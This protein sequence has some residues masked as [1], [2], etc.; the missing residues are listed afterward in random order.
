MSDRVI[1]DGQKIK[2][3]T[4]DLRTVVDCSRP[5]VVAR[6]IRIL[7]T[8]ILA[9]RDIAGGEQLKRDL[10]DERSQVLRKEEL[11]RVEQK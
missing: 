9:A 5:Q 8:R 2:V 4:G 7:H 1:V 11:E 6:V 3:H 10:A